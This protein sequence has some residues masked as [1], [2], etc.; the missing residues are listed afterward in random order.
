VKVE[1]GT[2][3]A[4]GVDILPDQTNLL[5]ASGNAL[6]VDGNG[7]VECGLSKFTGNAND[8][9]TWYEY[10]TAGNTDA[11]NIARNLPADARGNYLLTTVSE[12]G[13]T[14]R[15]GL[16]QTLQDASGVIYTRFRPSSIW[17]DWVKDF[18]KVNGGSTL[19]K[20]YLGSVI[21]GEAKTWSFPKPPGFTGQRGSFEVKVQLAIQGGAG[22]AYNTF[23]IT[24]LPSGV[25]GNNL[26][27]TFV[28]EATAAGSNPL[29]RMALKT[30]NNAD[31]GPITA[32]V[33]V[34]YLGPL[35]DA[36]PLSPL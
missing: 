33:S 11:A 22:S 23:D 14:S 35:M 24:G 20:Y 25:S 29:F 18:S 7:I 21:K 13:A 19:N 15:T 1:T 32:L 27:T 12:I 6:V 26:A 31:S 8:A 30:S 34:Q 2:F 3:I 10:V 4:Y 28:Y 16:W 5:K 17:T 36:I 9:P